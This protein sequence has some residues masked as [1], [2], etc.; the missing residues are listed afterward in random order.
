MV[1]L[2]VLVFGCQTTAERAPEE[3]GS[4]TGH[5]K[6]SNRFRTQIETRIESI[7][8]DRTVKGTTCWWE[9]SG[10]IVG[11]QLDEIA[12]ASKTGLSIRFDI[13]KG[14][15]HVQRRE[16][17]KALMWEIRTRANGTLTRPLRTSLNRTRKPGCAQR[18]RAEPRMPTPIVTNA[19]EPL[20]GHWTGQWADGTVSEMAIPQ[21]SARGATE[22]TYCTRSTRGEISIYDLRRRG[23]PKA[24]FDATKN[25]ITFEERLRRKG[26]GTTELRFQVETADEAQLVV[27]QK[28]GRTMIGPRTLAMRR[29]ANPQGCLAYIDTTPAE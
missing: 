24:R 10:V 7:G 1:A 14:S 22:A 21:T 23:T 4:L 25:T 29:G 17:R 8:E 2:A 11:Q 9:T 13:G 26:R 20:Y 19:Q 15:F 27:R 5:W 3:E 28:K 16:Q 18:F 6:G 12:K